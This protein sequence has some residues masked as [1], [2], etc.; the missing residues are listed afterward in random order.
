MPMVRDVLLEIAPSRDARFAEVSSLLRRID[1]RLRKD[2]RVAAAYLA[3]FGRGEGFGAED[4]AWSSLNVHV[5]VEDGSLDALGMARRDFAAELGSPLLWVEAPQNAPPQGYYLMALYDG[6]AGPYQVDWYWHSLSA[7]A[8]PADTRLLF[9]RVGLP[10]SSEPTPW[11]YLA[12]DQIPLALRQAKASRTETE[13]WA[14]EARNVV[15]LF[16]AMVLVSARHVARAPKDE[17]LPFGGMLLNLLRDLRCHLSEAEVA[18]TPDAEDPRQSAPAGKLDLLRE[19][20]R[21][22]EGLM[23]E[24]ARRG[25]NVPSAAPP[26]LDRFLHMVQAA[27]AEVEA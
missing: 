7:A 6:E 21:E 1:E 17:R 27:I 24:V 11:G 25:A 22:M 18:S 13:A 10:A 14:E 2:Q 20:G 26:R 19:L 12:D 8:V 3:H 15:G 23:A 9:D 16:W 4:D 5:V